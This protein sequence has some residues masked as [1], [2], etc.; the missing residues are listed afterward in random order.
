MA[1]SV[2]QG[3]WLISNQ[4]NQ[5]QWLKGQKKVPERNTEIQHNCQQ[6]N[7]GQRAPPGKAKWVAQWLAEEKPEQWIG[8][9]WLWVNTK[10][11]VEVTEETIEE[12]NNLSNED[13]EEALNEMRHSKQ[14][15]RKQG[16]LK[17]NL[18]VWLWTLEDGQIITSKALLDSGSMG[19]CMSKHFVK[20]TQNSYCK[21]LL[22]EWSYRIMLKEYSLP[23]QI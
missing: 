13:L 10:R 1:Q 22:H 2:K 20:K 23:Y 7:G 9:L 4:K 19:S 21:N 6:R 5:N 11:Q 16:S 15:I 8:I 17:M 14:F 3:I 12:I 18:S